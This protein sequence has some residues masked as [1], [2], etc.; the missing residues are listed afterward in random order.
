MEWE[1]PLLSKKG[2]YVIGDNALMAWFTVAEPIL[3]KNPYPERAVAIKEAIPRL[4]ALALKVY[5]GI[6]RKYMIVWGSEE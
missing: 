2:R 1:V 6:G 4:E 3:A 5:E